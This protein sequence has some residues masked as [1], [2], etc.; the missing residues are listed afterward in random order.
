MTLAPIHLTG[1]AAMRAGWRLLRDPIMAMRRNH[2]EYGRLIVISDML[3]FTRKVKVV[4]LGLPLI[5]AAGPELNNEILNNPA[6]WRPVA[7][8]PGGPRN[9]AARRLTGGCST[10]G[11]IGRSGWGGA[12]RSSWRSRCRSSSD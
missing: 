11:A 3:P 7:I 8:F 1:P 4:T 9:S 6:V 2:A 12:R 5:L 10:R